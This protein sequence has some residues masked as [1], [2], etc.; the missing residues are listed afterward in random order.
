MYEPDERLMSDDCHVMLSVLVTSLTSEYCVTY[1]EVSVVTFPTSKST[2]PLLLSLYL[3]ENRLTSEDRHVMLSV[4]STFVTFESCI[5]Y[6]EVKVVISPTRM[7]T[8]ALLLSLYVSE[9][10]LTSEDRHVMLSV[11][12]IVVTAEY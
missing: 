12:S 9:D 11:L 4:L 5:M 3:S 6:G 2:L 10:R 7:S 1:G 8:I